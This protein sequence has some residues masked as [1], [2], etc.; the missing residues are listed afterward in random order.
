MDSSPLESSS[1]FFLQ[2]LS[3]PQ[4]DCGSAGKKRDSEE[5]SLRMDLRC[6][7]VLF[8]DRA[9]ER[10]AGVRR[11]ITRAVRVAPVIKLTVKIGGKR[12]NNGQTPVRIYLGRAEREQRT[13][14]EQIVFR[15][16][17]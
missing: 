11:Y 8:A 6:F 9:K 7:L 1:F 13:A 14:K 16:D 2:T 17:E 10:R 4:Y 15:P 12:G 3:P 5:K